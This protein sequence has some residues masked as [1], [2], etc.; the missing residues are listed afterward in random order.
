MINNEVK[1]F[2]R[3]L[4]CEVRS[5]EEIAKPIDG[6]SAD[7]KSVEYGFAN[8]IDHKSFVLGEACYSEDKGFTQFIHIKKPG[9]ASLAQAFIKTIDSEEYFNGKHPDSRYKLDFLMASRLDTLNER[10]KQKLGTKH[11]P[12]VEPRNFIPMD[13]LES[14]QFMSVLKLGWN[15]V[16]V[17]GYDHMPNLDVLQSDINSLNG[18]DIDVYMGVHDVLK[19]TGENG[20][21]H[22]IFMDE[23]EERFPV[24]KYIWLVVV[25]VN[26]RRAAAFT[27]LNNPDAKLNEIQGEVLCAS[28]CSEMS[29]LNG[30]LQDDLYKNIKRGYVSCCAF[31]ELMKT[32]TEMPKLNDIFELWV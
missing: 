8:P 5:V 32:V 31:D 22:E 19:L 21:K 1:H 10:L 3:N 6:C 14:K 29:W 17:I 15:Y 12:F 7:M 28:M 23:F 16:P 13:F 11:I 25:N 24:P 27:I 30:L 2:L 20:D 4:S 18:N 9:S 26:D